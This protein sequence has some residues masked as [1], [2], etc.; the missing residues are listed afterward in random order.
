MAIS[1]EIAGKFGARVVSFDI[2]PIAVEK[3]Y[4]KIKKNNETNILPN[5]LDLTNPTSDY[6]WSNEERSALVKRGPV[7]CII[8][9]AL[10]HHLTIGNNIPLVKIAKFFS[11]L[12][13][14]LV[15]EFVP[16]IDSQ[17][18]VLLSSRKDIFNDYNEINFED[19]F[20]K[21]FE[22]ISKSKVSNSLRIVY[23]FKSK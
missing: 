16:K 12:C 10:V 20:N 1:V 9:L 22:L 5:L 15:I 23:L 17:V 7:D 18:K 6:G 19:T 14:Y 3:N 8:A 13:S 21:Y 11:K 2:D 4:L